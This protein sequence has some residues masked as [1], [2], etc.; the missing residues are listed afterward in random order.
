MLLQGD[1]LVCD[2]KL[3]MFDLWTTQVIWGCHLWL[4]KTLINIFH[5]FPNNQLIKK[6]I[7]NEFLFAALIDF[8]KISTL[9]SKRYILQAD[10]LNW[11]IRKET[12]AQCIKCTSLVQAPTGLRCWCAIC[13]LTVWYAWVFIPPPTLLSVKHL[14]TNLS[15]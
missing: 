4:W 6:I 3:N 8:R 11:G 2:S 12:F 5:H 14:V 13:C 1:L 9:T 15:I 7:N 10:A